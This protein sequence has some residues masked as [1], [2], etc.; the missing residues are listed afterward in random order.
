MPFDT[1]IYQ[2]YYNIIIIITFLWFILEDRSSMI[3]HAPAVISTYEKAKCK[4]TTMY[5]IIVKK[6]GGG[7]F[8]PM[9]YRAFNFLYLNIYL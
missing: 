5:F 1:T 4:I 2:E 7:I 6:G 9:R 3:K 8:H